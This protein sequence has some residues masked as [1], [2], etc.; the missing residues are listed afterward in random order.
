MRRERLC[1]VRSPGGRGT[2]NR[3]KVPG[4]ARRSAELYHEKQRS[5]ERM[6]GFL[7]RWPGVRVTPGACTILR[8]L[9]SCSTASH[10]Q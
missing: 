2:K 8:S 4:V 9:K 5:A 3:E 7:N 6:L 10:P 1:P